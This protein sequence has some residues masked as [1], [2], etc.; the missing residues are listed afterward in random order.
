MQTF[1]MCFL[2]DLFK[3][4]ADSFYLIVVVIKT[5]KCI[6]FKLKKKTYN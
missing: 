4:G 2:Y 3:N 5:F 6:N 1:T